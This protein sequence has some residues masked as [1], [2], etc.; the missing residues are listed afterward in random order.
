MPLIKARKTPSANG[1]SCAAWSSPPAPHVPRVWLAAE[2][3]TLRRVAA[4]AAGPAPA[5]DLGRH[6]PLVVG[7]LSG[8]AGQPAAGRARRLPDDGRR[9]FAQL[10]LLHLGR[11][12][13]RGPH[14]TRARRWRASNTSPGC[15]APRPTA[16]SGC[17]RRARSPRPTAARLASTAAWPT[18][19]PAAGW[20]TW[21]RWPG[22]WPSATSSAPKCLIR[23]GAPL[24]FTAG[25]RA[26]TAASSP[27]SLTAR[28]TAL[29]DAT[30][31]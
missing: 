6:A 14:K 30:R 8:L 15:W 29:D 20:P 3:A 1:S 27:R 12:V 16:P 31:R 19:A 10:P 9:V 5:A 4:H 28:L 13:R 21:C 11:R 23:V 18:S 22:G 24:R 25:D 7:R 17:S 26:A 2:P